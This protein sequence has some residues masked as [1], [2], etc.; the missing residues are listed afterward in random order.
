MSPPEFV[1]T[2]V[3]IKCTFSVAVDGKTS[4]LQVFVSGTST[5]V[6]RGFF[7]AMISKF[8]SEA[9]SNGSSGTNCAEGFTLAEKESG[10]HHRKV[11]SYYFTVSEPLVVSR[12]QRMPAI[13]IP[14]KWMAWI[15]R[16]EC[17]LSTGNTFCTEKARDHLGYLPKPKKK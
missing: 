3:S 5:E 11:C 12:K 7:V 15:N 2:W 17:C 14:Y 6:T 16:W 13:F 1:M 9:V 10:G 4:K 8:D